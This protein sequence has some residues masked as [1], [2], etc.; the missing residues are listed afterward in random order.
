[1]V[2]RAAQPLFLLFATLG[3]ASCAGLPDQRLAQ[4]AMARGDTAVAEQ[5]YQQLADMGYTEAQ[6]G[7]A[8]IYVESGDPA[9]LRK[10]EATYRLAASDSPRAA[11]RLGR[12]LASKP[13]ASD[14]ELH[15]AETLLKQAMAAGEQSTLMPLALLYLQH[16]QSFPQVNAQQQISQWLAA[17]QPQAELAQILLYRSQGTYEQHL[18][19]VERICTAALATQ[20]VCYVE[21]ATVYQKRGQTEQQQA[22]VT[23]LQ[24]AY[25]SGAVPPQRVDAVAQVLAD[26]DLGAPDFPTA[27]A[28][29]ESI[30]PSYPAAWVSLAQLIYDA[31]DQGSVDELLGY[32]QKGRDAAQPRAELLLGRLY[33]E[34]KL[35]PP[36]PYKAEQH[37]LKAAPSEPSANYYLGQIYRRGY[38]GQVYPDKALDYLLSAARSGQNSADY[39]LAQLFTQGR[40]IQPDPVNAYVFSQLA[41][42]G[43]K[44]E[45]SALAAQVEQ[46]L[47][48]AQRDQA[49]QRLHAERQFRG[50]STMLPA[51]GTNVLH[52]EPSVSSTVD[53]RP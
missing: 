25:Q 16:P 30:A 23:Q 20:D 46:Q 3:L 1:M 9:Q 42:Q 10:A 7:M 41:V 32:L 5:N 12:L 40:G 34:G 48:P 29:L 44:P 33:Y 35:I 37:L 28:L 43:G 2:N 19:D 11:A 17:G 49:Q 4:E 31:P 47:T 22:L 52:I 27:K 51:A 13:G 45:A 6:V 14:A 26:P 53:L 8:D 18:A 21:L 36:D 50:D 15:E 39:A 24:S 38:L